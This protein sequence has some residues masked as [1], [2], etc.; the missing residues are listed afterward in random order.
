MDDTNF[1]FTAVVPNESEDWIILDGYD[2]PMIKDIR[3]FGNR[4]ALPIASA[5]RKRVE[6]T[7]YQITSA[8]IDTSRKSPLGEYDWLA[9]FDD[10]G[11][12]INPQELWV[13]VFN[14]GVEPTLRKDVWKH[15]LNVFPPDLTE[16]DREKY[17]LMKSKVYWQIRA[18]WKREDQLPK[19]EPLRDMVWKD[20]RRTD[21]T[22][23]YFDVPD[24]HQRLTSLFNILVTYAI[25]NP[26]VSY[27]QGMSDLAAPL[28][29]VMED[30]AVTF[31]CFSALMARCKKHFLPDG[32]AMSLKFDHLTL[33]VQK[34]DPELYKY[35]L[36]VEADDM[37]FCYRWLVLDLKREFQFDDALN[38]MEAIW[39]S[40]LPPPPKDAPQSPSGETFNTA[41][42]L[43]N[44]SSAVL[45]SEGYNSLPYSYQS[46]VNANNDENF[47]DEDEYAQLNINDFGGKLELVSLPDPYH[48]GD[49]NPFTLFLCLA[50]L[51]LHRERVFSEQ[52][53]NSLASSFDKKVRK[54]D[55][56]KVLSK[57][58]QLFSQ[59]LRHCE[60]VDN[61][62]FV[63]LQKPKEKVK[64][65]KNDS[66]FDDNSCEIV[67]SSG[68][69]I[70]C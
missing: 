50:I 9:H 8:F 18:S 15:L 51:I 14:W 25:L 49:G 30:E 67:S 45:R 21:R 6:N 36:K 48:L 70:Q 61:N 2:I 64:E 39:S 24:E 7:L 46:L 32:K 57:A 42:K 17:L 47:S 29:V 28:L 38:I 56:E 58:R 23:P 10:E 43:C 13:I 40:L 1:Y 34:F 68:Q 55:A 53:Y 33:L 69:E 16:I 22:Y 65:K 11:R 20:V 63:S 52:D 27:A 37:F 19:T 31:T 66:W 5:L 35:L 41:N 4:L 3:S 54:H 60:I 62:E 59:Y 44:H 26:D 12:L